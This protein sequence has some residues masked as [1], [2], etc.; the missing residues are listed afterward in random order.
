MTRKLSRNFKQR[1]LT[2]S[3]GIVLLILS[4][5]WSHHGLL[6]ILFPSLCAA[7]IGMAV[8][9]FYH[10]AKAKGCTPLSKIGVICSVAY[11]YMAFFST[12]IH[13]AHALPQMMLGLTLIGAFFY[14]FIKGTDPLVNLSVTLFGIFYLTIPLSCILFIN[15]FF[16]EHGSQDGRWWVIYLIAVTKMTDTGAYICGKLFGRHYLAP[17]ISPKKT[18]EGA[19]GGLLAALLTSAAFSFCAQRYFAAPPFDL[20]LGLSLCL[21]TLISV[22]AQ[23]GDLA[24]SLLKRDVGV[25]DSNQLPGLGGFMDIVDSLVFTV[26]LL[27]LFLKVTHS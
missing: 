6:K 4:L 16:P 17:Y 24:E 26:P 13:D 15:Y 14:Y 19:L 11:V 9:E 2:S 18:W 10:I 20:D 1:I 3:I 27:Y 8:W 12:Q 7:I 23:F 5:Y 22:L 25:K 21:G